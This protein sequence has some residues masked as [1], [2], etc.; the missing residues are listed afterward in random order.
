MKSEKHWLL[1][2][3]STLTWRGHHGSSRRRCSIQKDALKNFAIF[4]GKTTVAE[5]FFNKVADLQAY[6]FFEKRLQHRCFPVKF[7]K[8]FLRTPFFTE[9]LWWL[10]LTSTIYIP[11]S[12]ND[13]IVMFDLLNTLSIISRSH[14]CIW[15]TPS[16]EAATRGVL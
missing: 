16:A 7:V 12:C 2:V 15:I 5:S 8:L 4:T 9:H 3:I 6:N 14:I 13:I 1:D 11:L 10:L